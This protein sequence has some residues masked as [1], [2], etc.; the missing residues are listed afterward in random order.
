MTFKYTMIKETGKF[1]EYETSTFG[2]LTRTTKAKRFLCVGGPFSGQ[3]NTIFDE[4]MKE[5]HSFNR[6]GWKSNNSHT[7]IFVHFSCLETQ[8]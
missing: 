1:R 7:Q 3:W 8:C 2:G 5:Y 6:A 4:G